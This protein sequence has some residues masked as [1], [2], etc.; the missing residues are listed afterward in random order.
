MSL[1][2]LQLL[3][4]VQRMGQAF[5][6][7][8][9]RRESQIPHALAALREAAKMDDIQAR[10]E[11]WGERWVG[12]IPTVEPIDLALQAPVLPD[13]LHVGAVDGSQ[14][15]PDRHAP[16][17]YSLIN[18]GGIRIRHGSGELPVT[19]SEA[20]LLYEDDQAW[21]IIPDRAM[22]DGI[23]DTAEL[24]QLARISKD[25]PEEVKLSLLDNGLLLWIASR[26]IFREQPAVKALLSEFWGHMDQ[27]R[28]SGAAL[29]GFV[30]RP[31]SSHIVS[32]LHLA[33]VEEGSLTKGEIPA[34]PFSGI[35]D[36]HLMAELLPP[37]HRSAIFVSPSTLNHEYQ[38]AGHQIHF[39]YLH[40]GRTKNI[41]RIEI[42]EWVA[43]DT[44][45][46]NTVHAGILEQGRTTGG[47]PYV[48][49]RAHELA[50]VTQR[51][52]KVLQDILIQELNRKGVRIQASQ[53]S[54]TKGWTS[55]RRKHTL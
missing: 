52:R 46:M 6:K 49:I 54:V 16:S 35:T 18:I 51:D 37:G 45:L 4:E 22:I 8:L 1:D 30:D 9:A 41:V 20:R 28:A 12:A 26:P 47:F 14:I 24:G 53:K 11:A 39:F 13:Q 34:T 36:L 42:P 7:R 31:R 50:V 43:K 10:I 27:L 15:Y 5:I 55:Y 19:F 2:L 23:R 40:S 33:G 21:D 48:L 3:P 29:A 17:L 44:S 25:T 38:S 32:M